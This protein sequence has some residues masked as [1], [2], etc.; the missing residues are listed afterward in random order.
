MS[1]IDFR[2]NT[3]TNHSEGSFNKQMMSKAKEKVSQYFELIYFRAMLIK[4]VKS[5]GSLPSDTSPRTLL[6]SSRSN[7]F[8]RFSNNSP[9]DHIFKPFIYTYIIYHR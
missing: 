1:F 7:Y 2:H 5:I 9:E 8:R 3:L 4:G 6:N